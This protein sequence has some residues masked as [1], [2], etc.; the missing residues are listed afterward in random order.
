MKIDMFPSGEKIYKINFDQPKVVAR[1]DIFLMIGD[2]FKSGFPV[3]T[4]DVWDKPN[5]WTDD[6]NS[7]RR[8]EILVEMR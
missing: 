3:Y 8:S 7:Q 2:F 6:P 5:G 4:S 1:A